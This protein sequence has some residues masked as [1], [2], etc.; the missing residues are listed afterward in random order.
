MAKESIPLFEAFWIYFVW[1]EDIKE[2]YFLL[3]LNN[4]ILMFVFTSMFKR[5][6]F[7]QFL[8]NRFYLSFLF[9]L[10]FTKDFK[11]F[12]ALTFLIRYLC[13]RNNLLKLVLCFCFID[14]IMSLP[15]VFGGYVPDSSDY[16]FIWNISSLNFYQKFSASLTVMVHIGLWTWKFR[17]VLFHSSYTSTCFFLSFSV[18]TKTSC[19]SEVSLPFVVLFYFLFAFFLFTWKEKCFAFVG[20]L[21]LLFHDL[22]GISGNL[23]H[24]NL[25]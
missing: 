15:N 18:Y 9:K 14:S 24:R 21:Y 5:D 17:F 11:L 3:A 1:F 19:C 22:F 2:G 4:A 12:T 8:L 25:W 13:Y 7:F 23:G 20:F 10:L 6:A 16:S